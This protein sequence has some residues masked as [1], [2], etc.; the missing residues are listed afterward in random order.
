MMDA[1]REHL[2]SKVVGIA[3][4]GG[5]GSNCAVSLARTG[6]GKII[7]ADFDTVARTNLNR[8]YYFEDQIGVPKVKALKMNIFRIDPHIRVIAKIEKVTPENIYELFNEVDVLVE[9]M[10][11]DSEKRL[12]LEEAIDLWPE[13]PLVAGNGMAGW[14]M[15]DAIKTSRFGNLYICGDSITAV[16]DENPPLSPRVNIVANMQANIALDILMADFDINTFRD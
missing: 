16:S 2:G 8:Q 11:I 3:G 5:L 1:I 10:D 6:V 12:F 15:N 14:G 13:R 7:V 4:A 9:A